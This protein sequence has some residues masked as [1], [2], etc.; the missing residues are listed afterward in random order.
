LATSSGDLLSALA[1]LPETAV[2]TWHGAFEPPA[3][4]TVEVHGILATSLD[5]RIATENF[6]TPVIVA[7]IAK[8]GRS[9]GPFSA[10]PDEKEVVLLPGTVLNVLAMSR[11][12]DTATIVLME[13]LAPSGAE[14]DWLPPTIDELGQFV[15]EQLSHSVAGPAAKISTPGKFTAPLQ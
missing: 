15:M 2:L 6:S 5:P 10:H 3:A 7:I 12:P 1:G 9:I 14:L 13:E 8:R 4:A 11:Q